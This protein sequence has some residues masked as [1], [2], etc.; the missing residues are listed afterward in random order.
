MWTMAEEKDDFLREIDEL[1][2]DLDDGP[3]EAGASI[4]NGSTTDKDKTD[5]GSE[6]PETLDLLSLR[7]NL[8]GSEQSDHI[9]ATPKT[10]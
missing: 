5:I 3:T 7:S 4:T 1:L 8:P 9:T 10:G 6:L 2:G